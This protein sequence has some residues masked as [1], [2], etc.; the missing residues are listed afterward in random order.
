MF[1]VYLENCSLK[2]EK[3]DFH[4]SQTPKRAVV[5]PKLQTYE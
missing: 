5:Q 3:Y 4:M 1:A 2:G